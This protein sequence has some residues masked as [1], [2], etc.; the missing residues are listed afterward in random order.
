LIVEA[1]TF[2]AR[3]SVL[4]DQISTAKNV[5]LIEQNLQLYRARQSQLG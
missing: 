5:L 4:R 2:D 1:S 3:A